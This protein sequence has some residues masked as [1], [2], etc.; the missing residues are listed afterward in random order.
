MKDF[1][2][3]ITKQL[4][5][6]GFID[7]KINNNWS[8]DASLPAHSNIKPFQKENIRYYGI[9]SITPSFDYWR[10]LET[11]NIGCREEKLVLN[12]AITKI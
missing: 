11:L 9:T 6:M 12:I 4:S 8:I 5:S 3:T 1:V 7:I 2:K 10:E